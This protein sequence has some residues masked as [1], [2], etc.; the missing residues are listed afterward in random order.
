MCGGFPNSSTKGPR[1]PRMTL[2]DAVK[3]LWRGWREKRAYRMRA[4][5]NS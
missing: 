1:P 2:W 3:E 4:Q 5:E